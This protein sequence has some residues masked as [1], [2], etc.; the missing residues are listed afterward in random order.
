MRKKHPEHVNLERW[1]VSYADFITLLFAFFV[2]MYA[3]SQA[4][5][6]KFKQVSDSLKEA[7][8]TGAGGVMTLSESGAGS[9]SHVFQD[10]EVPIGG[11]AINL[12]AGKTLTAA[13]YD[14]ELIQ[15]KDKLEES[16]TLELGISSIS[17]KLEMVFDSS[18][19]TIRLAAS[20]FYDHGTV[21]VARD[22]RPILDRIGEILSRTSRMIRV[23]GHTDV[24]EASPEGY[25]TDWELSAAR[26]AWLA[27]YYLKR[28]DFDPKRVGVAGY[29]HYRPLA[30][31]KTEWGRAKNRRVEIVVLNNLYELPPTPAEVRDEDAQGV[32]DR[33]RE[34]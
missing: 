5:I 30:S 4:D 19:L 7:F 18:G 29:S 16:I 14:G 28:F 25:Y 20:D 10:L 23:E 17:E 33:S 2:V 27:R 22:M 8:E 6:V 1:L 21:E 32:I 13:D 26:A 12:P 31:N 34:R 11:R 9:S 15:L 24:S 3:I